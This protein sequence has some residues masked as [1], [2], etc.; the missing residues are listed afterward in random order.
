MLAD[1]GVEAVVHADHASDD[2]G[3]V[4][5]LWNVAAE[6]RLRPEREWAGMVRRRFAALL[7][8]VLP[9]HLSDEELERGVHLRLAG[10]ELVLGGAQPHARWLGDALAVLLSVKSG[11]H[12][13]TPPE[14]TWEARG[15]LDRWL[16]LGRDNLSRIAMTGELEH[17]HVSTRSGGFEVVEGEPFFTG[18][19]A[20]V[21]DL[22]LHR[23]TPGVEA[24]QGLLV[25]VPDRH[26]LAWR[27]VSGPS[28]LDAAVEELFA[29][30]E[31]RRSRNEGP[32]SH[33]VFHVTGHAWRQVTRG[34]GPRGSLRVVA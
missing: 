8:P 34:R 24:T 9:E 5:G 7:D 16:E 29:H 28:G 25:V 20:L 26:H 32:L 11:P 33:E 6:C 23:F 1:L 19:T 13:S 27:P 31:R 18:S 12:I 2:Q 22:L 14:E 10:P 3:R 17:R 4:L 15:G 21:V 30:A